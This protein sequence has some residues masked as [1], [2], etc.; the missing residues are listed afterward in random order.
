LG[1][2]AVLRAIGTSRAA[3]VRTVMLE[4]VL[5]TVAGSTLG[6]VLGLI[7][8]RYLDSILTAIPGL[9][10]VISFFVAEPSGL[11]RGALTVLVAGFFAGGYPA[12]RAAA[13]PIAET[14]RSEAE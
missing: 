11:A 14:L 8:A 13:T 12:W 7:T 9:P 1:E 3:I 6:I 10:S 5:L 2:L 4:G